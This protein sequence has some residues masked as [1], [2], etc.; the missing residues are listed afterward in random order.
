MKQQARGT[1]ARAISQASS[2]A[3]ETRVHQSC[4]RSPMTWPQTCCAAEDDLDLL[5]LQSPTTE[6]QPQNA[7][8]QPALE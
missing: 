3:F 7:P 4:R 8:R 2:F 5:I 6:R 1:E